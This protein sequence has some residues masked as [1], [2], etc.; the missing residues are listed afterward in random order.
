MA[1][2][3]V[4]VAVIVVVCLLM[5]FA[6]LAAFWILMAVFWMSAL[7][8]TLLTGDKFLGFALAIPVT[9]LIFWAISAYSDSEDE[10]Q[11]NK[12]T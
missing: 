6:A 12:K 5:F 2:V 1:I 9:G 4:I 10:K 7:A 11:A 3:G 8:I